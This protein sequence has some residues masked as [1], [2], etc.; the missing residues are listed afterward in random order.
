MTVNS[1]KVFKVQ[2]RPFTE[3][4]VL[5]FL[6]ASVFSKI[7]IVTK[8]GIGTGVI[9]ILIDL[10]QA[11]SYVAMIALILDV[12]NLAATLAALTNM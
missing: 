7:S 10:S 5:Y 3:S 1:Y 4:D 12:S 11:G 9:F 8:V 6:N 2:Y